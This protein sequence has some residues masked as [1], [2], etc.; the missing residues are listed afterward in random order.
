[1]GFGGGE[2]CEVRALRRKALLIIRSLGRASMNSHFPTD[3]LALVGTSYPGKK[4]MGKGEK[5]KKLILPQ[6][7]PSLFNYVS[8]RL[9]Y[10][11]FSMIF[12]SLQNIFSHSY[13]LSFLSIYSILSD[14]GPPE[15]P[16]KFLKMQGRD[17][18]ELIKMMKMM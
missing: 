13:L 6:I 14:T 16:G 17:Q 8:Y 12:K 2:G 7:V 3:A 18:Q 4:T 1:M 9:R 11:L 10:E 15:S 5:E